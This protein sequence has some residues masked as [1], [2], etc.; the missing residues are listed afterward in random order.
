MEDTGK[1]DGNVAGTDDDSALGEVLEVEE[2]VRVEAKLVTGNVLRKSRGTANGDD[3]AVG[4]KLALLLRAAVRIRVGRDNSKGVL[5]VELGVASDVLDTILLDVCG[6]NM[7]ILRIEEGG[8]PRLRTA[9][10]DAVQALD[11]LVPLLLD[12][13]PVDLCRIFRDLIA[14]RVGL[15]K[16]FTTDRCVSMR[17]GRA[18]RGKEGREEKTEGG[19]EG[20]K[21][22]KREGRGDGKKA[23]REDDR[24]RREGRT[25]GRRRA[26]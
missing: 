19:K 26:T 14:V 24:R 5:V 20:G 7:S 11:V 4:S 13:R 2:T 12:R 16:L 3:E 18:G 8:A 15:V 22:G 1:L 10:V 21:E 23:G 17:A 9:L 6:K 25:Q